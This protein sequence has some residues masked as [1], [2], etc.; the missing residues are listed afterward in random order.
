MRRLWLVLLLLGCGRSVTYPHPKPPVVQPPPPFDAGKPDAGVPD[1]GAPDAGPFDAG[2]RDAGQPD[3]GL[4]DAGSSC[5]PVG[6]ACAF[7]GPPQ[8]LGCVPGL[9]VLGQHSD[10]EGRVTYQ[11]AFLQPV[12]HDNPGGAT[13]EQRL[14]LH[15]LSGAAP[16]VMLTTGYELYET[17]NE[18][19]DYFNTNMLS[20]EHRFF[21][22]SAVGSDY[23]FLD[24]RQSANDFHRI[25]AAFASL[26]PQ[27]WVSTGA[28]KGGMTMVYYRRFFPCD[29]AGTVPYVAPHSGREGDP[30]YNTFLD[31]VGG[32][33]RTDCR[34]RLEN[35]SRQLLERR[36]AIR[37]SLP[38]PDAGYDTVGGVDVA[39]EVLAL[40]QI[41]SFWQYTDPDDP[42]YGCASLPSG[43]I[44]DLDLIDWGQGAIGA[45]DENLKPFTA[46]Y[47]QAATQLGDPASYS[48]P[49]GALLRYPGADGSRR[50][51][52]HSVT[53]PPFDPAPMLD[54]QQW[55]QQHGEG[56]VF[57]YGELDPWSAGQFDLG[58][59]FDAMKAIA[60]GS[61][62][63]AGIR[64]LGIADRAL[65]ISKLERWLG[66][67]SNQTGP[68]RATPLLPPKP[69]WGPTRPR[70][71]RLPR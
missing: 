61:N 38:H 25:R 62:H 6:P 65:A 33:A 23:R 2:P 12:D 37:P 17:I 44:D 54:V 3:A 34:A 66:Q 67:K 26:Y 35:L 15:H 71:A 13:F 58:Q 40:D 68:L 60:P 39:L 7:S 21:G 63:F 42:T 49:F 20:I 11:L 69:Q 47:Y 46:Y 70:T 43:V 55:L 16:M 48:Q 9:R 41:F 56:F 1:A 5:P 32:M 18:L 31:T 22:T 14:T 30:R 52:D 4:F 53:V 59:A 27:P 8:S 64:D 29:V 57:V 36:D 24:I 51:I 45:D 10:S 19:D 28:S 50:Y